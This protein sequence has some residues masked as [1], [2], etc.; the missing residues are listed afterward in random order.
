MKKQEMYGD[1]GRG[2]EREHCS[3]RLSERESASGLS[4]VSLGDSDQILELL[5]HVALR[6]KGFVTE[7]LLDAV[8]EL[9][10]TEPTQ[11]TADGLD[12][13]AYYDGRP[14]AWANYHLREW[15]RVLM[16]YGGAGQA[17][18]YQITETP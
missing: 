18:R 14:N 3:P 13:E 1:G 2:E 17:R 8:L 11:L 15:K 12:P 7:S 9:G 10:F 4:R 16:I 6:G 5:S